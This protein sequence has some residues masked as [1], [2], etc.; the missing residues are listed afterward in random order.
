MAIEIDRLANR[1]LGEIDLASPE[2][3]TDL[4]QVYNLALFLS[5]VRIPAFGGLGM[6]RYITTPGNFDGLVGGAMGI[7][8]GPVISG[9]TLFGRHPGAAAIAVADMW[10]RLT[11]AGG[12]LIDAQWDSPFLRSLGAELIPRERFLALL[13]PPGPPLPL[14]GGVLPARR[15]LQSDAIMRSEPARRL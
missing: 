9:D 13:G 5:Q 4:Y 7:G 12:T 6:T 3:P 14:P 11:S 15:L 8:I 1:I 2:G 10:A